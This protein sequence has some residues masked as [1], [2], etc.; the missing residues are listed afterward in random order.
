M[1]QVITVQQLLDAK[2][3][4]VKTTTEDATVQDALELMARHT[5]SS[6]PVI[7]GGRLVGIVSERDY[8]RKAVPRRL[9]P[10]DITVA[11]IMT[12]NVITVSG[13]DSLN[14]CMDLMC[15]KRI[16]HLPVMDGEKLVGM[17]SITEVVKATRL[18]GAG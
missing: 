15:T 3:Q 2:P 18:G 1:A 11:E 14:T 16:R 10:W 13:S 6:L 9:A 5:V 8:I 17:L 7:N 4:A 12:R